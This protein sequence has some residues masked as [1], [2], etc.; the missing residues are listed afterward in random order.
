MK[1]GFIGAGNMAKAIFAGIKKSNII[2][3]NDVYVNSR[4]QESL[5]VVNSDYGFNID[6]N[7]HDVVKNAKDI[8]FICVKPQVI[9]FVASDIKNDLSKDQ[10]IVSI[11]AG[12]TRA[13]LREHFGTE[14]VIRIMP[15]TPCLVGAGISAVTYDA[16]VFENDSLNQKLKEVLK[17]VAAMGEYEVVEEKYIDA[18]TQ[19]SGASPAWIFM[20]IEALADGGVLCGLPRNMAYRFAENAVYGSGALAK[21]K[22]LHPGILKDMV[23]SPAGTT[24]EGVKVLEDKGF[25]G[26][27]IDAVVAAYMKTKKL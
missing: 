21:E 23:T 24:I 20:M 1:I 6:I 15:N 10:I 25:R 12:K 27:I 22:N 7:V 18:I 2:D 26:A 8:I 14:N 19:V 17:I 13:Y 9:D 5:N 3:K 4:T 16:S 11:V